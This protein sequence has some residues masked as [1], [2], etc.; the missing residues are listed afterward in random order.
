[1]NLFTRPMKLLTAVVLEQTSD[2]VV[3]A[4]LELGVMDFIHIDRLDPQQMQ[5]LSSRPSSVNRMM[6]EDMRHRVEA[7]LKQG[8]I[9][10]PSSDILDVK[11]LEKPQ[12]DEYRKT[13]DDLTTSLLGLKEQQKESNQVVM[14]LEEIRRYLNENKEEYLDLRVGEIGHGNADDLKDRLASFGG[15]L[16]SISDGEK[17]I[18]LTLRRDISQVDPLLEK[19]GWV[20]SSDSNL[21]KQALALIKSRLETEHQKA[22]AVRSEIEHQVDEMVAQQQGPLFAIWA[23]LRLNELSDQIRS[24][25]AYTKNTTLFSGWVPVDQAENVRLAIVTASEEQCVIEWTNASALPRE[26]VPVAITSPRILRPFQKIVNNFST[27]EY[28]TIN[29]TIFVMVAYLIM[30]GLMFADVG[31][32]IVLLLIGILG[33]RD[34]A[35]HPLKSDGMLSRT[36]MEL[37]I[38]LGL[39]SIVFGVLFGSY[40]G[41]PLFPALWFNYEA[42]VAGHAQGGLIHDVFGILGLTVRFGIVI[43]YTGLILNWI[44]LIRKKS[45]LK[46]TLDKNGLVGG[47][48]FGVGIYMG[49]GFVASN[50]HSFPSDPWIAPVLISC[51]ALL[52][53]RG[54]L[55]YYLSSSS[56]RSAKGLGEHLMEAVIDVLEIFIGYLS[57]TLSFMRVAGLGIAHASLMSTFLELSGGLHSVGGIAIFVVGNVIVIVLEGLS[58]GIQALRLNYYEFFS[59]YFTGK[60][61]A[62]EPVRLSST[63]TNTK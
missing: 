47:L 3:K 17:Y 5:K 34:Y 7:L 48:L 2:A 38:Y 46:L 55:D 30:F 18:S 26:Q 1:M 52:I 8:H 45:F 24:Y 6:L 28:G 36:V 13:I 57:N 51:I 53:L 59:R 50:Y 16:E 29:P 62:Y 12:L 21:Q 60:G 32:G 14:G 42:A 31:Q 49:F 37:L 10:L 40:F 4:L 35:K 25:F 61:V 39:C 20:E 56:E 23:N 41:L 11:N 27:P 22:V 19:F 15:L 44:N 33:T 43:I 9:R 58:S 63:F 54:V